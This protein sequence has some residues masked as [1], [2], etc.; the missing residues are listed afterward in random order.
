MCACALNAIN[1][2]RLS[3]YFHT[4][5][6]FRLSVDNINISSMSCNEGNPPRIF[7]WQER[8]TFSD[9]DSHYS[10]VQR[11]DGAF[12]SPS[13]TD[14]GYVETQSAGQE[15]I[16]VVANTETRVTLLRMEVIDDGYVYVKTQ[17]L[18]DPS[19]CDES[20]K[21][22]R[23]WICGLPQSKHSDGCGVRSTD[24]EPLQ[25]PM[26]LQSLEPGNEGDT[27]EM[28]RLETAVSKNPQPSLSA[29]ATTSFFKESP[30]TETQYE[31]N[32][33]TQCTGAYWNGD[34]FILDAHKGNLFNLE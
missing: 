5:V 10:L 30:P 29:V 25:F 2:Q 20:C 26:D 19:S 4:V 31:S 32:S 27:M 6:N 24:S 8:T 1:Y 12:F 28:P 18:S 23:S 3:Q 22:P 34:E 16:T 17:P 33:V 11:E 9:P 14:H 15:N 13:N 7:F 21:S